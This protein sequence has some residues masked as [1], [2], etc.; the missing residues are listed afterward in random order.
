MLA[1]SLARVAGGRWVWPVVWCLVQVAGAG[2]SGGRA[3]WCGLDA[4]VWAGGCDGGGGL[5]SW[6]CWWRRVPAGSAEQ[7]LLV[8]AP[9]APYPPGCR[10]GVVVGAALLWWAWS[11]VW[12]P[13]GAGGFSGVRLLA[14]VPLQCAWRWVCA[15]LGWCGWLCRWGLGCGWCW[16]RRCRWCGF[17]MAWAA[18][19]L[20]GR[21]C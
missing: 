10:H 21:V 2:H 3:C 12:C 9:V 17:G 18:V 4:V 7:V 6:W 14:R 13:A 8:V 16:R 5:T 15:V 19:E 20:V 1:G 11:V